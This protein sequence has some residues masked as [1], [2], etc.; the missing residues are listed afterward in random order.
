MGEHNAYLVVE[1]SNDGVVGGAFI[2]ARTKPE[3]LEEFTEG[4]LY[5]REGEA[6]KVTPQSLVKK[7]SEVTFYNTYNILAEALDYLQLKEGV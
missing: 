5:K 3:A 1:K 2:V 6:H 7:L 4:Y